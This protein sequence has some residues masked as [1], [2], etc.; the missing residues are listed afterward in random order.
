MRYSNIIKGRFI[1][2][3]N[4]FIAH[5]E[6]NEKEEICHV[7]NT[8]RCRELLIKGCN[9]FL[10]ESDNPNRKTKY[11]LVAVEKGNLLIN[12]DSNAPNKVV[13]EWLTSSGCSILKESEQA[14]VKPEYKYKNSRFD[15][16]VEDGT[17]KIF[18]EVKGVTLEEEGVVKFPDAPSE[19]AV[20][21]VEE[22]VEA[23][24]EGYES[25]V[26]FVVQMKSIKYFTPNHDTQ[27]QFAEALKNAQL[28]GVKVLAYDC[29]VTED[30]LKLDQEVPVHL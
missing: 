15:F 1:E 16:Y 10:E 9:V 26:I 25:Y 22:L 12:M 4:R 28:K 27:P 6:I 7:K 8:G 19:R 3:P 13:Q 29:V 30:T 2:R 14:F 20:K 17:R 24:N 18:I 5:V 11:D 21:H 23:L